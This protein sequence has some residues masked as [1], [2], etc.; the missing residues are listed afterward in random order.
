MKGRGRASALHGAN[1]MAER[2]LWVGR[3]CS[4]Q[5]EAVGRAALGRGPTPMPA[6]PCTADIRAANG[7]KAELPLDRSPREF[8]GRS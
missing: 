3:A 7:D 4:A 6:V 5:N 8:D 2:P 1:P